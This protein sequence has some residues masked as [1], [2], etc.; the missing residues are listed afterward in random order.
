M[1][2]PF[3][4]KRDISK[5][6]NP[7]NSDAVDLERSTVLALLYRVLHDG[8]R[9][10]ASYRQ[11]TGMAMRLLKEGESIAERGEQLSRLY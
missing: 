3:F 1:I 10:H 8:Q 5:N 7:A 11:L 2:A 4:Q 9:Q 6:G